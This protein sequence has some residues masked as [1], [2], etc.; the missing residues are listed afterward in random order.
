MIW[1][2]CISGF[3]ELYQAPFNVIADPKEQGVH[4][5]FCVL[6]GKTATELLEM[7]QQAFKKD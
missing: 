5:Q 7:L 6:L 2:D 4:L 3:C 1:L